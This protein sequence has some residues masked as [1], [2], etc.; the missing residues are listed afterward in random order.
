MLDIRF[1]RENP[2]RVRAGAEKKHFPLDLERLLA[3]DGERRRLVHRGDELKAEMN[4]RSKAVAKAPPE[5]RPSLGS[6]L[7]ALKARIRENEAALQEV[8]SAFREL[9]LRVPNVP[10]PEVPEGRDEGNNRE[11]RRH[12]EPPGAAAAPL[13]HV[14]LGRRLRILDIEAGARLS[15]TR[16]Y[17]LK[18]AG[19]ALHHA[20]L[21]LAM[22]HM[23]A[24]G[25]VPLQV[26]VLV[27]DFAME[28]TGFYPYGEDQVYRT[29]KEGLNLIGTG[30][31]PVTALHAGEILEEGVLPL[32]YVTRTSCFRREA[33]AAG[34]DTRGLYRVHQFEKVEQVVLCRDDR[35]LSDAMHLRILEN[36]EELVRRLELP[37]RVVDVCGGDLG[38]PQ[39]RKFDIEVWMPSR[40]AYGET[41]SASKFY[42]FQ[43]RRLRIRYKD[44]EKTVRFV[45]TLNNTVVAS[46]RIL[47]PLL[48]IHQTPEGTVRV[49]EALRPYMGGMEEI[50]PP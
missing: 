20:V 19:A 44:G 37:Y 40:G 13:D 50:T 2:D 24:K 11:L 18:G 15:G 32:R 33:G 38:L 17:V 1:I 10:D 23:Q 9:L 25:F 31:V 48:E 7:K 28:G 46:P 49:P 8:D 43:A 27:R 34:R 36:A 29:E 42:D 6:D 5:E 14:E 26:P 35:A 45:H 22:D 30:E 21:A 4:T 3:L 16:N 39:A 47:I 41:H 12:G